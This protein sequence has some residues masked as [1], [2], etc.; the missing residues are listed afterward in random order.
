MSIQTE[1]KAWLDDLGFTYKFSE[2]EEMCREVELIGAEGIINEYSYE[3]HDIDAD[4]KA[5]L[6]KSIFAIYWVSES[7]DDDPNVALIWLTMAFEEFFAVRDARK[8][9]DFTYRNIYAFVN[10]ASRLSHQDGTCLS[11]YDDEGHIYIRGIAEFA[12]TEGEN[13]T[14]GILVSERVRDAGYSCIFDNYG[15][16]NTALAFIGGL[17]CFRGK[18]ETKLPTLEHLVEELRPS[19][20]HGLA[21]LDPED[22]IYHKIRAGEAA[23]VD[24]RE[25]VFDLSFWD[26]RE[27]ELRLFEDAVNQVLFE[28]NEKVKPE[29]RKP[30]PG[31]F[32]VLNLD[33][34]YAEIS[35]DE[36]S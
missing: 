4:A 14:N 29:Y 34:F 11:Y 10:L 24:L 16:R 5:H 13:L 15:D 36:D 28:E 22:L 1:I 9:Y 31:K 26:D 30:L 19:S 8:A 17:L 23:G 27:I 21:G 2:F 3:T 25:T 6:R 32:R 7:W 12:A 20:K 35:D 18:D 33:E